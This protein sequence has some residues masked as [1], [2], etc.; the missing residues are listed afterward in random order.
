[1]ASCDSSVLSAWLGV[2]QLQGGLF[3]T[4]LVPNCQYFE[5]VGCDTVVN[6]VPN[7]TCKQAANSFGPGTLVGGTDAGL[8]CQQSHGFANVCTNRTWRVWSVFGPPFSGPMY[9]RFSARGDLDA[10]R[11]R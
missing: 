8:L 5:C 7:A 10:K 9:L 1:M 11:H 3:A 6:E 2:M 4:A